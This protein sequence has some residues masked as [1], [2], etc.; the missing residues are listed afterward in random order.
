MDGRHFTLAI[1]VDDR[2]QHIETC[3]SSNIFVIYCELYGNDGE[4][5]YEIAVP[6][7]SGDRGTIRLNKWG[8]FQRH[9]R[10]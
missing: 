1:K 2:A 9:K 8:I 5:K 4:M 3:R 7:T 10:Q 6:V